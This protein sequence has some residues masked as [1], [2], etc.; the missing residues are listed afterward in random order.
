[1]DFK[2][3]WADV[4]AEPE[5]TAALASP[6]SWMPKPI[7]ISSTFKASSGAHRPQPGP[8]ADAYTHRDAQRRWDLAWHALNGH[9]HLTKQGKR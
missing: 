8:P 1:M 3:I 4:S 6:V 9:K 2:V 5:K 7:S